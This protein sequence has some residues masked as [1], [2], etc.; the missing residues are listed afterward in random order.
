MIAFKFC[1]DVRYGPKAFNMNKSLMVML[2]S[3]VKKEK[4]TQ[5]KK[6]IFVNKYK[7]YSYG[8]RYLFL[9]F[10]TNDLDLELKYKSYNNSKHNAESKKKKI[11]LAENSFKTD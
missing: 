3:F 7:N 8:S 11:N 2:Q 5:K 10:L 4:K 9:R 6:S 1:I